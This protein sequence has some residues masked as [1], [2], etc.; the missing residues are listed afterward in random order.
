MVC[1]NNFTKFLTQPFK[2]IN[3]RRF[4]RCAEKGP[5]QAPICVV[6]FKRILLYVRTATKKDVYYTFVRKN[7]KR[8]FNLF[9]PN[10]NAALGNS[11]SLARYEI[12]SSVNVF[13]FVRSKRVP[14]FSRF[15]SYLLI[16]PGL[17]RQGAIIS[18]IIF[19]KQYYRPCIVYV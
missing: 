13:S 18:V 8:H 12:T 14:S 7:K 11:P 9:L 2:N 16:R 15:S 19:L 10:C 6:E 5:A 4:L 1:D 17:I 3:R